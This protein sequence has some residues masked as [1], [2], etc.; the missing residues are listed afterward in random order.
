MGGEL[1]KHAVGSSATSY[2]QLLLYTF[3][4]E[5]SVVLLHSW[6]GSNQ[7]NLCILSWYIDQH[8]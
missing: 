1:G 2:K 8:S 6:S 3:N 4:P 7:I 5:G